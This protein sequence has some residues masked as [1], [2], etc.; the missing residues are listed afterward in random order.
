MILSLMEYQLV[1]GHENDGKNVPLTQ[2]KILHF[3]ID[4]IDHRDK[5][6]ELFKE[7][8]GIADYLTGDVETNILYLK[9]Q[10]YS[11]MNKA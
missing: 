4:V 2:Y 6:L 7:L 5:R 3:L 8:H 9:S 10:K 11:V 1:K